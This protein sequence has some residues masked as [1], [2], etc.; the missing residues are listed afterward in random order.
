M[1]KIS[2]Y[3]MERYRRAGGWMKSLHPAARM[4]RAE[5]ERLVRLTGELFGT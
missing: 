3:G 1:Q 5:T 4:D 2:G